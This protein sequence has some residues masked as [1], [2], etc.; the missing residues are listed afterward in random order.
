[1]LFAVGGNA[2]I[3]VSA[4]RNRQCVLVAVHVYEGNR[5]VR[6]DEFLSRTEVSDRSIVGDAE[7]SRSGYFLWRPQNVLQYRKRAAR[8]IQRLCIECP[9][10][11]IRTLKIDNVAE[12]NVAC[13]AATFK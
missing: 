8:H 5:V 4:G 9:R 6:A 1:E 13:V 11:K 2:R 3:P 10:K 12:R 7:Q